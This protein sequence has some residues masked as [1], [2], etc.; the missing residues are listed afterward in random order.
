MQ[1]S[2]KHVL[3]AASIL[4]IAA[5]ALAY[6]NPAPQLISTGETQVDQLLMPDGAIYNGELKAGLLHGQGELIWSSG[7]RYNGEFARG[8]YYG[9]G[10]WRQANGDEYRGEFIAGELTGPGEFIGA[11][12]SR[13]LGEFLRGAFHGKGEFISAEGD[14]YLGNFVEGDLHGEGEFFGKNGDHYQGE[15]KYWM[16][17]GVG[18]LKEKDGEYKGQFSQGIFHGYGLYRYAETSDEPEKLLAGRWRWGEFESAGKESDQDALPFVIEKALYQQADLLAAAGKRILPSDPEAINLYFVGV[19][20]FSR[21]DV[22][23]KELDFIHAQFDQ[24]FGTAGRSLVL[25]NHNDTLTN[26]PMATPHSIEQALQA[27]ASKMNPDKDILFLYLTSHGSAKHEFSIVQQGLSLPDLTAERLGAMIKA[28]PIKWKVIVVSACYSGGF[29]PLLEGPTTLVMTASSKDRKSFG[30]TDTS[31]MTY[32]GRAYFKE[33]LP[34]A[35]SFEAAF[36]KSDTLIA[37]WE[38]ELDEEVIH[39]LP[40][41]VMGEEIKQYLPR[42]WQTIEAAAQTHEQPS[43]SERGD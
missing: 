9:H 19:A 2:S 33:A 26:I 25:I 43:L 13:Y 31:E 30:C 6:F 28:L 12:G 36:A 41:M 7:A 16:F 15:F 37:Q 40:Q 5:F 35:D 24:Q 34:E 17:D 23:R 29:I 18:T 10:V 3:T 14:R 39:S 11:D 20:G 4:L 27:V 42:W 22:F 21:Q 38:K 8:V 32:F 1:L